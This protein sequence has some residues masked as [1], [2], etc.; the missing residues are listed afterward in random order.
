MRSTGTV[1]LRRIRKDTSWRMGFVNLF[2]TLMTAKRLNL[3]V[4]AMERPT[5]IKIERTSNHWLI[6]FQTQKMT[7][8]VTSVMMQTIQTNTRH[9]QAH[10]S[11]KKIRAIVGKAKATIAY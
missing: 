3:F 7:S 5:A 6:N 11:L 4:F 2:L 1:Y 8:F 9:V 10:L